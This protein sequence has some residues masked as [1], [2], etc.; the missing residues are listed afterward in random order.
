MLGNRTPP[1][2]STGVH[3]RCADRSSSTGCGNRDRLFTQ[4]TT[5]SPPSGR[6]HWRLYA[7]TLGLDPPRALV[8][9]H[10]RVGPA[11]VDE[12]PLGERVVLLAHL[13]HPPVPVEQRRRVVRLR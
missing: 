8:R 2:S 12:L 9:P 10:P 11:E 7:S 6:R 3:P 5:S 4:S 13:D 1:V